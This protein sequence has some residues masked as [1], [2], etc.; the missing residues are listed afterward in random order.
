[1][2]LL[3]N[4]VLLDLKKGTMLSFRKTNILFAFDGAE[5]ERSMSFDLP[6]TPNNE[7]VLQLAKIPE[8]YGV[9]MRRRFDAQLQSGTLVRNGYL[10]VDS[11]SKGDYK[12]IFVTGEMLGLQQ[13]RNAGTLPELLDVTDTV[14]WTSENVARADSPYYYQWQPINYLRKDSSV[15]PF[16]CMRL[17][18]V[19]ERAC[20]SIGVNVPTYPVYA[21]NS[22]KII[23]KE[24][25]PMQ[26]QAVTINRP[27]TGQYILAGSGD[28]YQVINGISQTGGKA[29]LDNILGKDSEEMFGWR[30]YRNHILSE[31][32]LGYVTQYV[33]K[34]PMTV[35]FPTDWDDDAYMMRW[36]GGEYSFYGGRSFV[37]AES[38]TRTGEPLAGRSVELARGD[39][40]IFVRENDYDYS[41][42]GITSSA[43]W[44][45]TTD[46]AFNV[47]LVGND[48]QEGD[49]VALQDNLPNVTIVDLLRTIAAA[50]GRVLYY[51]EANG[52]SFDSLSFNSWDIME[53]DERLLSVDNVRRAFSDYAQKSVVDMNTGD[54]VFESERLRTIYTIDNDNIAENKILQ[55][56]PFSEGGREGMYGN[57]ELLF[58]RANDLILADTSQAGEYLNRARL[59]GS[60]GVQSLCTR[61]T[62]IEAAIACPL[63]MFAQIGCKVLLQVG[64]MRYVWTEANWS[65]GVATLKLSQIPT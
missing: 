7:R 42:F 65:K 52:V 55:T 48:V 47:T 11:F 26:E 46:D 33:A 63:E 38:V 10:Y 3:C 53:I 45:F 1:M 17:T 9:G 28:E 40:F 32:W 44:R 24:L 23:P 36:D 60:A 21:V 57:R 20:A 35:V 39:K 25:K 2:Q 50:T 13:I 51:T 34:Q 64:G 61:S 19:L 58:V 30:L 54:G 27:I 12:A 4:G 15:L 22:L 59:N 37:K 56:L 14:Q 6:A 29:Y 43:G 62:M 5:C 18:Y 41:D 31:Q 8:Y 16:P 49:F